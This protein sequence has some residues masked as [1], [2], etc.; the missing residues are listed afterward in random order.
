MTHKKGKEYEEI[1]KKAEERDE[2]YNKW[3]KAHADYENARKRMEKEKWDH[4]KFANEGIISRLFPIVDNFDMALAAMEKAEDKEAVMDGIK[5]VQKEFHRILD[6]NGVEK[7]KTVGEQFDPN[8]HDAVSVV[9]TEEEPDGV[10]VDEVR[11]GYTLNKRLLRPA[12]VRVAK[13]ISH[14]EGGNNG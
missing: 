3:L 8:F 2:Y 11:A 7:I 4:R 6:E 12:Q 5:L 1:K 13:N 9:E 14:V 10:I